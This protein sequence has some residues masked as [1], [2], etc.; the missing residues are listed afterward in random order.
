MADVERMVKTI[1]DAIGYGDEPD[2]LDARRDFDLI[3][4]SINHWGHTH[5]KANL[6][7]SAVTNYTAYKSIRTEF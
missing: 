7:K 6:L 3:I 1:K 2:S 5:G 4:E